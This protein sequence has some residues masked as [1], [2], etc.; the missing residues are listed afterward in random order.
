VVDLVL[1]AL[2]LGDLDQHVELQHSFLHMSS[3][4]LGAL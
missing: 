3:G 2:S 4:T 1:V